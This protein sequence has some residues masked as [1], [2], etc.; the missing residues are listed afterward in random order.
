[1][2]I[3]KASEREREGER[4]SGVVNRLFFSLEKGETLTV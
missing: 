3:M 2:V 1:M 4:L